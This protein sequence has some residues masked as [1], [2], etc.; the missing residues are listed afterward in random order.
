[1]NCLFSSSFS[2]PIP[3]TPYPHNKENPGR[4]GRFCHNSPLSSLFTDV[5]TNRFSLKI[6]N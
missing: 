3:I 2:S 1:M 4:Q 6:K 5:V